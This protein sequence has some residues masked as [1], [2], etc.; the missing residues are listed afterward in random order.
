MKACNDLAL[1][2]WSHDILNYC[3]IVIN[4]L[5][6]RTAFELLSPFAVI[7]KS[8]GSSITALENISTM[9][10]YHTT[11]VLPFLNIYYALL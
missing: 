10:A 8:Y 11:N 7:D 4:L 1:S 9:Y 2:C 6:H 5:F 3:H